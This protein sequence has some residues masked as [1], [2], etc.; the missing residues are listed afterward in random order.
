MRA[1]V[2][3]RYGDNHVVRLAEIPEPT[4][5]PHQ[6]LIEVH[7]ASVNPVD[8]KIRNGELKYVL[9]ARFPLILGSDLSGVV[10]QIGESVTRFRV[11]DAV[12]VRLD[13]HAS[14]AF[15]ERVVADEAHIAHKPASLSHVEAASIPLA[16]LTAWQAL[17][18]V[19]HVKAGQSVLVH[20]GSGGVGTLAIQLARH[21]GAT[22]I[23]TASA[24]NA[25]R[26]QELG[27]H[28]VVDYHTERFEEVCRDLD[29]VFDTL[30]GEVRARSFAVMRPGGVMVSI[31]GMPTPAFARQNG[32][33]L[34]LRLAIGLGHLPTW[35]RA[36][37]AQ[38]HFEYLFMR[39]SGEQLS[40]LAQLVESGALKPVLDQV[41]PLSDAT[42]AL[43]RVESGRAQGKVV[44]DLRA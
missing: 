42:L 14:G 36:R 6:E 18:E 28:R 5:K 22:V 3:D 24:R 17:T 16:G 13:K 44:M 8:Y 32:M 21:L 39:P 25:A 23:T 12:Y 30:G 41:H 7:A 26:L 9:P 37:R 11:G 19:A 2:I 27:A 1:V 40:Q 35:A 43:A 15:A 4:P 31:A 38:A 10:V 29:M 34:P 33:A 20:A